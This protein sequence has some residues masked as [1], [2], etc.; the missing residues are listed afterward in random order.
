MVLMALLGDFG[1]AQS[2]ALA[3]AYKTKIVGVEDKALAKELRDTSQLVNLEKDKADSEAAL[4][5]RAEDDL[6]RLRAVMR[7]A[8]YYDADLGYDVDTHAEPWQVT[9]KIDPGEPYRLPEV[10]PVSPGC[11]PP[12]PI[13]QFKP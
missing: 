13:D 9:V 7:A 11:G 4:S 3:A 1:I 10:R 12:P 6:D 5:R 2:S 8:G